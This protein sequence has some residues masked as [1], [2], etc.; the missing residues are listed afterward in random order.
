MENLDVI[1]FAEILACVYA[2]LV[3]VVP[4]DSPIK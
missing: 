3:M 4:L 2:L 1:A